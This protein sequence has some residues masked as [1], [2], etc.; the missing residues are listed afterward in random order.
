VQVSDARSDEP[1][2]RWGGRRRKSAKEGINDIGA[3]TTTDAII[4]GYQNV[5]GRLHAK[6]IKVYGAT[7]TSVLG[8]SGV[9]MGDNGPGHDA[10]RMVLNAFIRSSGFYDGVED[11]DAA[12]LGDPRWEEVLRLLCGLLPHDDAQ[13][14]LRL[15]WQP[16]E[17]DSW[18]NQR[19]LL[20]ARCASDAV[21]CLCHF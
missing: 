8:I 2:T 18:F 5:V 14:V 16:G 17:S 12:T 13:L 21:F 15:I 20:A 19:R 7:L 11:F 6:G 10:S 3:G 4:A 9:D 1:S